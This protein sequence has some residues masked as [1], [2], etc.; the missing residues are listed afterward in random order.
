MKDGIGPDIWLAGD[1]YDLKRYMNY[2]I[3]GIVTNTVVQRELVQK[4]GTLTDLTKKYLEVTDKKIAIEIDG[5]TTEELLAVGESFTKLS[6]QIILK[7]PCSEIA[8]EAFTVLKK[9]GIE[10][11]CTTVFSLSQAVVAAQAGADHILPFCE[12]FKELGLNPTKLVKDCYE[13]FKEWENKPKITAALVRSSDVANAALRD[14][15][16]GIIIFWPVYEE[17]LKNPLTDKWNDIF[18]DEWKLMYKHGHLKD[19]PTNFN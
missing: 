16:D 9:E 4:Y 6:D 19:L 14:G 5:E 17:I 1:P 3:K 18:M 13:T 11:F 8:L 10:T 12:P 2:G 15:A 7:I